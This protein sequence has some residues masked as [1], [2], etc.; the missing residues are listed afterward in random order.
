M[1]MTYPVI[2]VAGGSCSGKT[3]FAKGFS[4]AVLISMDNFYKDIKDLLPDED[5]AYN[6]D[7]P[8]AF[9]MEACKN[10]VIALSEGKDVVVPVYDYVSCKRVGTQ[11]IT[12]PKEGQ[13]VVLEGIFAL[14]PPLHDVGMVR[15]FIE[16]PPEIRVAR[17]IK[18]DLAKGRTP[19][20]TLKWFVKV[21]EGHQKYIEPSKCYA[22]LVVPFSY[23]PIV[24]SI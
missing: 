17:R 7:T 14:C 2:T 16:A 23:S 22:N 11:T 4:N 21:E 18:R 3:T 6:F 15:I 8:D 13:L 19:Q 1:N 10:A 24:F 5:G 20:E 12:S 9:D